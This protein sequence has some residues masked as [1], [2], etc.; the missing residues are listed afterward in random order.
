MIIYNFITMLLLIEGCIFMLNE[1]G[2]ES[3][4]IFIVVIITQ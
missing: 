4:G 2:G 3:I 1:G